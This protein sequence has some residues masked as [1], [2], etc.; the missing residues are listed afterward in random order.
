MY[1]PWDQSQV[2]MV[3]KIKEKIISIYLYIYRYK[4]ISVFNFTFFIKEELY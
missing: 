4:Y 3:A 1:P 2:E